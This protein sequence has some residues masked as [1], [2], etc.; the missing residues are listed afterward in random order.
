MK[1]LLDVSLL[2]ARI[3][4]SHSQQARVHAWLPGKQIR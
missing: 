4:Q 1:H 3:V 2:I